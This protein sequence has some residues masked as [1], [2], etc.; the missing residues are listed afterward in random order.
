M[1]NI[2]RLLLIFGLPLLCLGR[3]SAQIPSSAGKFAGTIGP[4][5]ILKAPTRDAVTFSNVVDSDGFPIKLSAETSD[6]LLAYTLRCNGA[7]ATIS[8]THPQRIQVGDSPAVA[9]GTR[10][11]TA[12]SVTN[13][14]GPN[15]STAIG[16][17]S[18]STQGTLILPASNITNARTMN[19][20]FALRNGADANIPF[21]AGNYIFTFTATIEA[22][23]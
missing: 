3:S 15:Y 7:K 4:L 9:P 19:V 14:G 20:A 8:F 17:T 18:S 13:S 11:F 23:L 21:L 12:I 2:R 6:R 22:G 1:V 5:C 10:Y 16:S